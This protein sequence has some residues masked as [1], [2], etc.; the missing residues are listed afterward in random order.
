MVRPLPALWLAALLAVAAAGCGKPVDLK[1]SVHVTDISSGWFDMGVVDG[2][3]KLVPSVTF[4]IVRDP[5]TKLSTLSLNVVFRLSGEQE[6]RDDVFVQAV[7]FQGDS[8]APITV[9]SQYGYTGEQPRAEMLR[10]SEFR[11]M[12]ARIFAR[13]TSAQWVPLADVKVTRQLLAH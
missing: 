5:G 6:D 13:Q 3:N 10:H 7:D 9:R 2:K 12:D 4:R 11:D 1:Q 8:T